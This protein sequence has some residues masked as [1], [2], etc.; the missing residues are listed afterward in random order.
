MCKRYFKGPHEPDSDDVE[1]IEFTDGWPTRQVDVVDGRW[2]SSLDPAVP[3]VGGGLA[4]QPLVKLG[5]PDD[6]EIT[7][8]EFEQAW[9]EALHR[10]TI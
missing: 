10:R 3:G 8:E 6:W 2:L 4:D 1:L 9:Q 7:A 5:L